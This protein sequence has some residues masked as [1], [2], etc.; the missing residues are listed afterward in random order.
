MIKSE[1]ADLY[2]YFILFYFWQSRTCAVMQRVCGP[3]KTGLQWFRNKSYEPFKKFSPTYPLRTIYVSSQEKMYMHMKVKPC[4]CHGGAFMELYFPC[5]LQGRWTRW[6][7]KVP[8]NSNNPMILWHS[9]WT[10]NLHYH[11]QDTEIVT[12]QKA[13]V[14]LTKVLQR[15]KVVSSSIYSTQ[16]G[17]MS[18]TN[19]KSSHRLRTSRDLTWYT[20]AGKHPSPVLVSFSKGCLVLVI[21]HSWAKHRAY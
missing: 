10:N 20:T 19:M 6:P 2:F 8:S 15:A 14:N 7:S 17:I 9:R 12:V 1:S 21:Y 13:L 4:K 18:L 11:R 16:S 5:S 3:F